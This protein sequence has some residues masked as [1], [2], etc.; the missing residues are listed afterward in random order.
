MWDIGGA[1]TLNSTDT[2][3]KVGGKVP[4][5]QTGDRCCMKGVK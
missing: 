3:G 1:V 2:V 4:Q 5:K